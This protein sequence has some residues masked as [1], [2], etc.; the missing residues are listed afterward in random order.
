MPRIKQLAFEPDGLCNKS[1]R[2]KAVGSHEKGRAAIDDGPHVACS[3]MRIQK[4]LRTRERWDK[5]R[6]EPGV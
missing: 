5:T 6:F 4:A 3:T 1:S 2:G